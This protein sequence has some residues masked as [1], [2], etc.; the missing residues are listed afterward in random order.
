MKKNWIVA[1]GAAVAAAVGVI[2]C[3]FKKRKGAHE[4][5]VIIHEN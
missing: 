5:E 3:I 4:H 2:V 1:A